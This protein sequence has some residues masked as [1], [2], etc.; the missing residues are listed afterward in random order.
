MIRALLA[1]CALLLLAACGGGGGGVTGSTAVGVGA[2]PPPPP[3][4]PPP[5]AAQNFATLTVDAGP[6]GLSSGP[7]GYIQYNVAY[8]SVTLCAP[9]ATTCQTID[10]VQVDTGSV[11]L[12]VLQSAL[13]PAMLAA[14][15]IEN[16]A[17]GNPLGEC[18]GFVDG[19]AFGSVRLADFQVGGEKVAGMPF[20]VIGDGGAF[21]AVP[22]L[23]SSGGGANLAALT[24]LGANGI[25][26]VGVTTT[27]CGPACAAAG[28]HSAAIYYD[29]PSSGCAAIV[30]EAPSA[31]AP[32]QQLPNPVAAMSVDNNGTIISLPAASGAQA[33]LT[34]TLYFGIGTET[35][36]ALG[37]ASVL[38]TSTSTNPNGAG[39]I[40]VVYN[41]LSLG[42]SFIDS[43]TN[44]FLFVDSA[45]AAC[46]GQ[47]AGYYCPTSP[48]SLNATLQGTN[49]AVTSVAFTLDNAAS[50]LATNDAVLP[51]IG[52]NPNQFSGLNAYPQSF[53]FGLPFFYGR[54]VYTA[55]EGRN[56]GGTTGPYYAF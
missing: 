19:Y 18:Y 42:E 46:T 34:G 47:D 23:C 7:N 39:L 9:G 3:T 25:I 56:A 32:F 22:S 36:N 1:A 37:G 43:G 48:L 15:P 28:G 38:L 53:D 2:S 52:G 21:A 14:L 6:A 35:N 45:I 11:G 55:I 40:N 51:G 8:V 13:S 31:S 10:H 49:Q 50:L 12:R 24:A 26:G 20:Q 17:N 41:G 54:K 4:P 29:C 16:D 30:A 27:D 44:L 33:S 5:P